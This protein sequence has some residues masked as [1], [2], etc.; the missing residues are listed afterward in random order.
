MAGYFSRLSFWWISKDDVRAAQMRLMRLSS[1]LQSTIQ[2][3][4]PDG[5]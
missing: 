3:G 2:D 5:V 4:M 1:A